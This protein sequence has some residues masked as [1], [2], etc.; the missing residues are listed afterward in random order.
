ML[1]STKTRAVAILSSILFAHTV[2]AQFCPDAINGS[3]TFKPPQIATVPDA[4][5]LSPATAITV[6]CWVNAK[7]ANQ[8]AGLVAKWNDLNGL[9]KRQYLLWLVNGHLTFTFSSNGIDFP[10]LTSPNV[11]PVGSWHHVAATYSAGT[12][13]LYT[14]GLQVATA[15]VPGAPNLFAS[16]EPVR[17]GAAYAGGGAI[18]HFTG[19]MDEVRIWNIARTAEEIWAYHNVSVVASMFGLVGGWDFEETSE[20]TLYDATASHFDGY[21]GDLP[22]AFFQYLPLRDGT[23]AS[24]IF[25]VHADWY[26]TAD[27]GLACHHEGASLD[28]RAACGFPHGSTQWYKYVGGNEIILNNGPTL[29]GSVVLGATTDVLT[30]DSVAPADA[31]DYFARITSGCGP[32]TSQHF[33]VAIC[34]TCPC[35]LNHDS[36]VDDSDFTLFVKAYNILDCADPSM[37]SGCPADFNSDSLVDDADFIQ[38]VGAYNNLVCP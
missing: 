14:D 33:H 23:F 1:T 15:A 38:F 37:P 24:T 9:N 4:P 34:D 29:S 10:Q 32:F 25:P 7:N 2:L 30:I 16:N 19:G 20:F 27:V 3:L 26:S 28:I 18:V 17:I 12:L 22:N 31:G 11:L 5:Q 35:D 8:T 6:E 13:R 36:F 21:L